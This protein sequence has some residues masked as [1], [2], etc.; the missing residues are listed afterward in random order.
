MI[1]K[2]SI[3]RPPVEIIG[4]SATD[5]SALKDKLK[6]ICCTEHRG[7]VLTRQE[8]PCANNGFSH[9]DACRLLMVIEP[10]TDIRSDLAHI[11]SYLESRPKVNWRE[12]NIFFG[13]NQEKIP[14][15]FVFPGQGSQYVHMGADLCNCHPEFRDIVRQ[16]EI[17]LS[18]G[19]SFS[20]L[21]FPSSVPNRE[22]QKR[23]AEKLQ[24]TDVAQPAI[25]AIS[26]V[27]LDLLARFSVFPDAVCGHSFGELTALHAAG[28]LDREDFFALSAA[29]GKYMAEAGK[30]GDAG[31]MM[32]VKAPIETIPALIA[33]HGLDLILANRNSPDQG[34][35]SGPTADIETMQNICRKNHILALLLPVSAAFHSRLVESAARPFRAFLNRVSFKPSHVPVYSNTTGRPYPPDEESARQLLSRHLLNPINFI[36]DIEAMFHDGVGIFVEVGPRAV[37][38]GLIRSILKD[39]EPITAAIDSSAG[40]HPA[41]TDL[42]YVLCQIAAAGHFVDFSQWPDHTGKL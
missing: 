8:G 7:F 3:T 33:E 35:L 16:A 10:G 2:D 37:L 39:R 5:R 25:G 36:D 17:Y 12:K 9:H 34:I 19:I 27:M 30:K 41:L 22:E 24:R 11:V 13:E 29:R 40:K 26:L 4:I 32:A 20:S 18:D 28:R 21:L 6:K 15:G 42:A 31:R 1:F 23:L 14:I 38:T